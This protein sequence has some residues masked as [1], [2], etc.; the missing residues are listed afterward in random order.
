MR[1]TR[2]PSFQWWR[3]FRT[4]THPSGYKPDEVAG[5]AA[6]H[7]HWI[8][9]GPTQYLFSGDLVPRNSSFCRTLG[10]APEGERPFSVRGSHLP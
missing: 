4:M 2:R 6:V 10:S 9:H 8:G 3:G 5:E 7:M 1:E